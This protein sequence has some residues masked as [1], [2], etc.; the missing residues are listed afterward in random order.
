MDLQMEYLFKIALNF[1]NQARL[2]HVITCFSHDIT[3]PTQSTLFF[4]VVT[5]EFNENYDALLPE[6]NGRP[7][8]RQQ[9]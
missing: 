4:N 5:Q 9:P 1:P 8:K 7:Q 6:Q 2:S 3:K